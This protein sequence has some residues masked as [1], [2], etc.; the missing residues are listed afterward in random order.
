MNVIIPIAK[1][2]AFTEDDLH[3][4][5][6]FLPTHKLSYPHLYEPDSYNNS[7]KFV[8]RALIDVDAI[9]YATGTGNTQDG[10]LSG[11][12]DKYEDLKIDIE[13]FGIRLYCTPPAVRKTSTGKYV[14]LNGKTRN[15]ILA[16]LKVKNRIVDIYE[17][18]DSA[19]LKFGV[20]SNGDQP[21]AGLATAA[22]IIFVAKKCIENGHLKDNYDDIYLWVNQACGTRFVEGK[23]RE[24]VNQILNHV[25]ATTK[26][27][28]IVA[29]AN[30]A[31][32]ETWM[33]V[34][35]YID[36]N[37]HNPVKYIVA[38]YSYGRKTIFRACAAAMDNPDAQIRIVIH[39]GNLTASDIVKCYIKRV[40][41]FKK[42][43][44]LGISQVSFGLFGGKAPSNNRIKLY[45]CIPALSELSDLNQ[46]IIF[47]K[48]DQKISDRYLTTRGISSSFS[49]SSLFD[50]ED[51]EDE[52][53]DDEVE[54]I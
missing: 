40:L 10:R 9:S 54:T 46:M 28:T 3:V 23:R 45:G 38:S 12:S 16:D 29:W 41:S 20:I 1:H 26:N 18:D 42:E 7:F 2:Y 52:S 31:E 8:K 53:E 50:N 37:G 17:C 49:S 21:P 27:Q 35:N 30:S 22:D 5:Q 33:Q 47:G 15:K 13:E 43:W 48:N 36:T 24:M 6:H 4:S 25:I 14:Y 34:N 39:T 44:Q 11:L 32:P 19:A 51:Y